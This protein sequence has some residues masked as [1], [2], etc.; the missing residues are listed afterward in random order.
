MEGFTGWQAAAVLNCDDH[1][2]EY[3]GGTSEER[4]ITNINESNSILKGLRLSVGIEN[5][6]RHE[7]EAGA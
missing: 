5:G 2:S 1:S 6:P 7:K 3:G 4:Y